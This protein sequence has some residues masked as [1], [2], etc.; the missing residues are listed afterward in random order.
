MGGFQVMGWGRQMG[1]GVGEGVDEEK[2][3]SWL[4][5]TGAVSS[6]SSAPSVPNKN[7]FGMTLAAGLHGPEEAIGQVKRWW[8]IS[9]NMHTLMNVHAYTRTDKH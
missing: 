2:Q 7:L 5:V 8:T 4:D 1:G 6:S 3:A 9:A